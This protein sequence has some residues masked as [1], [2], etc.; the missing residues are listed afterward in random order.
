V[1]IPVR[2]IYLE[3]PSLLVDVIPCR[4]RQ[5]HPRIEK[6]SIVKTLRGGLARQ[7][8]EEELH[9]RS[10]RRLLALV[11]F[12]LSG[13]QPCVTNLLPFRNAQ[14]EPLGGQPTCQN[15]CARVISAAPQSRNGAIP[16]SNSNDREKRE[17][18]VL[19]CS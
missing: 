11:V 3:A 10:N 1:I 8:V 13:E 9:V 2:N 16:W 5:L 6:G 18:S 19:A 4:Y 14:T 12:S 17:E 7:W 15:I